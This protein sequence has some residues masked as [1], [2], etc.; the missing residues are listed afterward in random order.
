[1]VA[2]SVGQNVG[3]MASTIGHKAEG[4]VGTVGGG[5]KSLAGTVRHAAPE[6]GVLGTAASGVAST[7]ESGGTYLQEHDLHA[8]TEDLAHLIRRHPLQTI[9]AGVGVGFLVGRVWRR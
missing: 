6:G 5:M 7:L 1:V 4:A 3:D 2:S 8:M 9:L